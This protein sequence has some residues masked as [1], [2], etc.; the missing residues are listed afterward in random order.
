MEESVD[1]LYAQYKGLIKSLASKIVI[2]NPSVISSED[3]TQAGALALL[4]AIRSY[5][6]TIGSFKTYLRRCII[7]ALLEQA[8]SFNPAITVDEKVRRQVNA[9]IKLRGEG[10]ED[11]E[12]MKR[13]GIRTRATFLSLQALSNAAV[14]IDQLDPSDFPDSKLEDHNLVM[15]LNNMGL[16]DI[17]LDF[18]SLSMQGC[19][20]EKISEST[21]LSLKQLRKLK[22]SVKDKIMQWGQE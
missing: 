10:I 17:E 20:L 4:T 7:N 18:I 22:A 2:N 13:L 11:D 3:L 9:I 8:N 15:L 5:D 6:P 12:I 21:G 14:D 16:S 19:D 1:K